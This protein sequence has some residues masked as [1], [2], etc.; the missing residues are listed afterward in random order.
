MK[1]ITKVNVAHVRACV[2]D[3]VR[4]SGPLTVWGNGG[5]VYVAAGE[6]VEGEHLGAYIAQLCR[7]V[8]ARVS[9]HELLGSLAAL[10]A[11]ASQGI[12]NQTVIEISN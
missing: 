10:K 1:T 3:P 7:G 11:K 9:R 2:A 8:S 4:P 12:T 6:G 5:K